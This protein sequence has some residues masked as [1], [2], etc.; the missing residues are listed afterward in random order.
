MLAT[1]YY[2][3]L[4]TEGQ[5]VYT[6]SVVWGEFWA[7]SMTHLKLDLVHDFGDDYSLVDLDTVTKEKYEELEALHASF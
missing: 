3:D 7:K 5:G 1:I 6:I 4:T 2:K